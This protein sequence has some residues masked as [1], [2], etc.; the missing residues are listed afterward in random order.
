MHSFA[1]LAILAVAPL[2]A[3]P[4]SG[5]SANK[6]IPSAAA[7][8]QTVWRYFQ[9]RRDFRSGDLI[10]R[11]DVAPLLKLLRA[12][13]LPLADA[14]EILEAVP[15]QDAFLVRQFG[16]P[17]GQKFM[18]RISSY[19]NVFDRLDR[20]ASLP[21]GEQTI[22]DLIRNPGGEKMVAYMT[23]SAAGKNLGKVMTGGPEGKLFTVPTGQIYTVAML[24]PRLQ[25]SRTAA[26]KPAGKSRRDVRQ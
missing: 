14:A 12:K 8:E 1:V 2:A 23:T 4:Q 26:L 18:R 20:L 11:E 13:G 3:G 22:R 7:V 17:T 19:P 24:L 25:E 6:P 5:T 15:D 10:T 16:T 9:G 21:N